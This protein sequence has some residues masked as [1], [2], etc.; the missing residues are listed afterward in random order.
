[1]KRKIISI[2]LLVLVATLVFGVLPAGAKARRIGLISAKVEGNEG[3]TV[4]A[5]NVWGDFDKFTGWVRFHGEVYNL[6][7]NQN[8]RD[9][10]LVFCRTYDAPNMANQTVQVVVNG[11]SFDTFVKHTDF[12]NPVYDW[13]WPAA[14]G[15]WV[16]YGNFCTEDRPQIGDLELITIPNYGMSGYW[17]LAEGGFCGP[18]GSWNDYG[19]GFYYPSCF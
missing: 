2:V 7:C 5:F 18:A 19:P 3:S 8:P 1:V 4:F 10:K 17:Y 13:P 16:D 9:S 11:F 14:N 12:C 6:R 15:S